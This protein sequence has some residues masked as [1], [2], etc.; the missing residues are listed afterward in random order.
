MGV[1]P[2]L[3]FPDLPDLLVTVLVLLVV[4]RPRW[5]IYIIPILSNGIF[6]TVLLPALTSTTLPLLPAAIESIHVIVISR[7]SP[8]G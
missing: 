6:F 7:D 8:V 3:P 4:I 1:E 2:I 5:V